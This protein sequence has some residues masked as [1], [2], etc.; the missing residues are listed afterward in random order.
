MFRTACFAYT[1]IFSGQQAQV[2]PSRKGKPQP[3]AELHQPRSASMNKT[4]SSAKR[5]TAS[6]KASAKRSSS[7]RV[8][9]VALVGFGTVGSSVARILSER[10]LAGLRLT[11]ICNRNVSRKK[12]DWLPD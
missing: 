3:G 4:K 1:I 9:K 11:H 6:A 7:D 8:C 5:T 2:K 10:A 12:V